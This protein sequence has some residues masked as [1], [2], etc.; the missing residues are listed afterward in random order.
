MNQSILK[1][2]LIFPSVVGR[3]LVVHAENAG[4]P[5]IAC[6]TI[7]PVDSLYAEKTLHNVE[8]AGF[9]T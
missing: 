5:R 4:K 2:D 6:A 3:G 9:S 7:K 1:L 8:G